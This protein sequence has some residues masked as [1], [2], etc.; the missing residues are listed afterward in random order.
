MD[1]EARLDDTHGEIIA[2]M[3]PDLLDLTDIGA[4]RARVAALLGAAPVELPATVTIE[5]HLV[6]AADGHQ[7]SVRLYRPATPT[8]AALFWMHGGGLVLGDVAMEDA[9]CAAMADDL[10]IVVASVEYRLA[11]EHPYPTPLDDC[12]LGFEWFADAHE[13]FG[14]DPARI[15]LGGGSAGA[16]LAAGLALRLRD[17]GTAQPC[18]QLLRFPMLDDRNTTP[19]S[20]EIT[21]TRVW[22]RSANLAGGAAYLGDAAGSDAV[23]AYA[24]AARAT[25]LAGL[26]PAIITVGGLDMFL[27]EDI[28]YANAMMAA[29]VPVELHVYPEAFH[30]STSMVPHADASQRWHRDEMAALSRALGV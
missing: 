6:D 13:Q 10:N 30:G 4:A 29:G 5:D 26:P 12:S 7:V 3:P 21:D 2:L 18:F 28:A 14:V 22:S 9:G 17:Q 8:G 16:G 15:A 19:S 11:P 24:A 23:D 1:F 25:D 20:Y 27:D